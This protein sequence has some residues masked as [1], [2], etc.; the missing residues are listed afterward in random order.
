VID[1]KWKALAK[2][3]SDRKRGVSQSDVYQMMAY[4]RI[5]GC[6]NLML[7][8]PATPGTGSTIVRNFGIHGGHERLTLT[9]LDLSAKPRD[10]INSLSSLVQSAIPIQSSQSSPETSFAHT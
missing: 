9:R 8:Y 4:S 2:E 5:Y 7:L 3:P 1:T 10:I 6:R